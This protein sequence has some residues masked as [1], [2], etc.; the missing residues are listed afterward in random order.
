MAEKRNPLKDFFFQSWQQ[1]SLSIFCALIIWLLVN[2]SITSN[3][4]FPNVAVKITKLPE[5]KTIEGLQSNGFLKNGITLTLKGKK[6]TLEKIKS[7]DLEIHIDASAKE[8]DWVAKISQRHLVCLN[9]EIDLYR[10]VDQVF[11]PEFILKLSPL[12]TKKIPVRIA[13]PLGEPPKGYQFLDIWPQQFYH[14]VSGPKQLVEDLRRKGIEVSFN[15]NDISSEDLDHLESAFPGDDEIYFFVPNKWKKIFIPFDKEELIE[16]NDPT[17]YHLRIVFL[18]KE[19]LPL[20]QKIPLHVFLPTKIQE[21]NSSRQIFIK[22][23]ELVKD[24]YGTKQLDIPLYARNVSRQFLDLVK[25]YLQIS[26]I[27]PKDLQKV[28]LD[29]SIQFLNPAKLEDLYVEQL[30]PQKEINPQLHEKHLRER[31]RDYMQNFALFT[32][33]QKELAL[34]ISIENEQIV[35]EDASSQQFLSKIHH[36][37]KSSHHQESSF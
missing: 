22:E 3:K 12:M 9:P 10:S 20:K 26:I 8:D 35:V 17:A 31:F 23:N 5:N 25:N 2:H 36:E 21:I 24:L 7:N 29:W 34:K 14:T 19:F 32:K 16:I 15:L 28:G 11:H 27:A 37:E 18:R 4:I 1:K 30:L 6:A 13:R 33:E